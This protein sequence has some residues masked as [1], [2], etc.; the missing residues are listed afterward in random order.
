MFSNRLK[1][2][3]SKIN[4][5]GFCNVSLFTNIFCRFPGIFIEKTTFE[6]FVESCEQIHKN[7]E[8]Q[9]NDGKEIIDSNI[10]V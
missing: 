10:G 5:S 7:E 1:L 8:I 2:L 4:N 3:S 9:C 6:V